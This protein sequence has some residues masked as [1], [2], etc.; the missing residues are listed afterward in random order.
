LAAF[1][2]AELDSAMN[3]LFVTRRSLW[4]RFAIGVATTVRVTPSPLSR[5]ATVQKAETSPHVDEIKFS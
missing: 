4:A 5:L 1:G 3:A 2:S